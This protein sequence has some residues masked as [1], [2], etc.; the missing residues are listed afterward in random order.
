MNKSM[1][2]SMSNSI[3]HAPTFWAPWAFVD[4]RWQQDVLLTANE[5]GAWTSIQAQSSCPAHAQ[6]LQGALLP[7]VVNAHSH[8]FQRAFAGLTERRHAQ[9]DDFWSWRD[10]MYQV[11]LQLTPDDVRVVARHLYAELLAGGFTHTCEFHYL[12][13]D[14]NGRPYAQPAAMMEALAAAASEVGMTL[15]LLPV[16]YQRAG[17]T[18]A[19]LRED[20]RRFATSVDDVLML[21]D[22]VRGWRLPQVT[23]G[24]AIHSLRAATPDA[25]A[26]LAS[27]V[28]DDA[29]PLHV[30]VA[31]QQAEVTQCVEAT[32]KRPLEWLAASGWL[33]A[34]WHIVHATHSLPEEV[35]AV[36]ASGAGVVLCPGTE[37]NLGDGVCDLEG[38]LRSNTPLSIGTDSHVTRAWPQELQLLEY[39]QRLAKQRR[40]VA[41]DAAQEPSTAARLFG[42][43]LHG[44]AVAAGCT[45]IG[46]VPGA[47]ADFV[48]I[49]MQQPALCGVPATYLL[50]A[51]VFSG[52]AAPFAE[53]WVGG[54]RA[55][56]TTSEAQMGAHETMHGVMQRLHH[57]I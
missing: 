20:Q 44:G 12:H 29:A 11:A 46:F 55:G 24:V 37:A 6:R 3:G 28:H 4:G 1:S 43:V 52:A 49:D 32:G 35:D 9:H 36:A 31:E 42:R 41:A 33:N 13:H 48:V 10:R 23:A 14:R 38:W 16:L 22:V 21:R 26:Q 25:M 39:G 53:T 8:A 47:R 19:T 18:S 34:R 40:N 45:S 17:F 27:A 7:G 51:L 15:T 30:H 2:N 5:H 54:R 56:Y 57:A 50:D